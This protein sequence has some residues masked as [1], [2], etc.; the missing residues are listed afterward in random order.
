M[1][2]HGRLLVLL[3]ALGMIAVGMS[4]CPPRSGIEP[5]LPPEE[6]VQ[7]GSLNG[8]PWPRT[9]TDDLG[10]GFT[11][12]GPPRRIVSIAPGLTEALFLL[13]AGDRVVGVT[14]FC[15]Y[16]PEART[17]A[18]IGGITNV[19]LEK[20]ISLQPDL[21]LITR[22]VPIA[23]VN[24]LRQAGLTVVG[25]DP[26]TVRD[27]LDDLRDLGQYLGMEEEAERVVAGLEARLEAVVAQGKRVFGAAGGPQVLMVIGLEPL[28][29]AGPGSIG[30]DIIRLCG[31]RNVVQAE[32]GEQVG[33]WPQYS[34]E[35]IVQHN[36]DIIIST[37]QHHEVTAG[38]TLAR[39][40]QMAGWRELEA[41]KQGRVYDLDADLLLRAGPRLID[42][43]EAAARVIQVAPGEDASV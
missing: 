20:V 42:G 14:E 43:L 7:P 35:R 34:L 11:L 29:V 32:A 2:P 3:S 9:F 25:K 18:V 19:N 10:V 15:D 21:V 40:R 23:V 39:L 8:Q 16:P 17:R 13:G 5:A 1:V 31:A 24:S 37:L 22:G 33:A 12:D 41:V 6:I 28:F 27:V 30:D 38:E 4:G 36:P 26:K